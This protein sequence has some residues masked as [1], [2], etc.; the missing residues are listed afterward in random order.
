MQ[1]HKK[2]KAGFHYIL[3]PHFNIYQEIQLDIQSP[4]NLQNGRDIWQTVKYIRGDMFLPGMSQEAVRLLS[5]GY[6]YL[7][8][9]ILDVLGFDPMVLMNMGIILLG[10]S[11]FLH[12][13]ANSLHSY[14]EQICLSSVHIYDNDP[15]YKQVMG[16]M[17]DHQFSTRRFHSS[18]AISS[19]S[20]TGEGNDDET[21]NPAHG[22]T[23]NYGADTLVSYH[24]I[25]RR[26][27]VKLQPFQVACIFRHRGRWFRFAHKEGSGQGQPYYASNKPSERGHI[28]VQCLSLSTAPL[29]ALLQEAQTYSLEKT[30]RKT[31]ICRAMSEGENYMYWATFTSRPPRHISTVILDKEKK[32]AILK[33]INEY[34]HP[35]TRQW[36]A[37]HGIPCRR[38]Y[39]FSGAPGTGKTSLSSALAGIFGLDI[40][41][42]SLQDSDLNDTHLMRLMSTVPSRCIV[43]LEDVDAA[44]LS[45]PEDKKAPE[46]SSTEPSSQRRSSSSHHQRSRTE[47]RSASCSKRSTTA[48]SKASVTLSGLLN[49]ID[50]VCSPEGR[51]LV[52]TTNAPES[53]DRALVRP[54]RIDMHVEFE[55]PSR[56]ELRE[57]FVSMYSDID[58]N[59]QPTVQRDI[60]QENLTEMASLFAQ[61]LPE[62]TLSMAAVQGFLLHYKRD[63]M[64]AVEEAEKWADETVRKMS[65]GGLEG[66]D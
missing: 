30:V 37:N 19:R 45:R 17:T 51:I 4:E 27:H 46:S 32:R 12:Y 50:G 38:G 57:L 11:T 55:L 58:E 9:F 35:V 10:F 44:G 36:Y 41:V 15:L 39:L 29:L 23:F 52:M 42:L 2:Y 66:L 63:P 18:R 13:V 3:S 1:Q 47:S 48:L 14:A 34:L 28:T 7:S 22:E 61:A 62:K 53:L 31:N 21:V 56:E 60:G 5:P 16:W 59:G 24:S 20:G 8:K 6:T 54:G 43:L 64:G 33:D 49:A 65:K 26:T 25:A 40:Y